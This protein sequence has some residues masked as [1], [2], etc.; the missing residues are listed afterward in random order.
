MAVS[1]VAIQAATAQLAVGKIFADS[2]GLLISHAGV[3]V[4]NF[5]RDVSLAS[6][7]Q[8]I[9]GIGFKPS[10]IIFFAAIGTGTGR[11][12]WGFDDGTNFFSVASNNTA[13]DAYS[14]SGSASIYDIASGSADLKGKISSFDSDG[15]TVAWT[16][17]G[18]PTGTLVIGFIALR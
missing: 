13:A 8:S 14:Y 16:K 17:T 4:G 18:S 9:T 6:G 3:K 12:S 11:A 5:T 7:N 2:N 15:F 10:A 1:R